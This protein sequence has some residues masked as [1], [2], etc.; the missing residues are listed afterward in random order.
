[1][2]REYALSDEQISR[3]VG[4]VGRG[5]EEA[6]ARGFTPLPICSVVPGNNDTPDK[7]RLP[8]NM[9]ELYKLSLPCADHWSNSL[10]LLYT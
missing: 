9:A 6:D 3:W 10:Y 8:R 4:E 5:F 1:M 2:M 7:K